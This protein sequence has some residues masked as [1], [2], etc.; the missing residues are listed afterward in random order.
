MPKVHK[1]NN[2]GGARPGA[3]NKPGLTRVEVRRIQKPLTVLPD[4][5]EAFYARYG[6]SWSRRVEELMKQD[7]ER[8]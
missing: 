4:I 1:K 6:R 5:Y 3:G 8:K 7:L 2:R